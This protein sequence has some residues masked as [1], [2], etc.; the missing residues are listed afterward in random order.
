MVQWAQHVRV[1]HVR[2]LHIHINPAT[3]VGAAHVDL[4]GTI[5]GTSARVAAVDGIATRWQA[6]HVR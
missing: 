4:I 6:L 2:V 5:L 3:Y 1:L